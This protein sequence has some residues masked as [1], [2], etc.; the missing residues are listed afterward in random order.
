[1]NRIALNIK[2]LFDNQELSEESYANLFGLGRGTIQSYIANKSIPKIETLQKLAVKYNLTLDDL[3]NSDIREIGIEG[4]NR[5]IS[6]PESDT[7]NNSNESITFYTCPE[8]IVKQKEIDNKSREV[9]DLRANLEDLRNHI[10]LLEFSL[11][12][13]RKNGSE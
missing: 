10:R 5:I 7:I 6:Y 12:K 11:G 2:Y 1:M 3:V 13:Y 8:C 4:R 9:E